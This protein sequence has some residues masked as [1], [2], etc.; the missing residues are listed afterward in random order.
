MV[1]RR[2]PVIKGS[3]K[4][5]PVAAT[6]L[7]RRQG[8]FQRKNSRVPRIPEDNAADR[9]TFQLAKTAKN[10]LLSSG[11]EAERT[12]KISLSRG[13]LKTIAVKTASQV[14]TVAAVSVIVKRI[15]AVF[16]AIIHPRP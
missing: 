14:K 6:N 3:I 15:L 4:T 11:L 5:A 16:P 9:K 1:K 13:S 10:S 8:F 12:A 7:L 2:Q